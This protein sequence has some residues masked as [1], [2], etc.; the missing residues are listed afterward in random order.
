MLPANPAPLLKTTL[1]PSDELMNLIR[2]ESATCCFSHF[3]HSQTELG[4][5]RAF[6]KE[7]EKIYDNEPSNDMKEVK[8]TSLINNKMVDE[9]KAPG[10]LYSKLTK[11]VNSLEFKA[12]KNTVSE[13]KR[14]AR[15]SL[16]GKGEQ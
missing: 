14:E 15:P 3:W 13:A 16:S 9:A 7:A 8:L 4:K 1:T 12:C 6:L 10:F 11:Y 2:K 5:I